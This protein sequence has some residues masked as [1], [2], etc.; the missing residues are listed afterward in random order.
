VAEIAVVTSGALG[1]VARNA[2]VLI[3]TEEDTG[4]VNILPPVAWVWNDLIAILAD[5]IGD[6]FC[7]VRLTFVKRVEPILALDALFVS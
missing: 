2:G 1:F 3:V 7:A 4:G 6:A 5:G